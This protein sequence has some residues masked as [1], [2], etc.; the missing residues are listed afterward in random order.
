LGSRPR[1]TSAK[2]P[3]TRT[4]PSAGRSSE[5]LQQ[6]ATDHPSDLPFAVAAGHFGGHLLVGFGR[7]LFLSSLIAAALSYHNN[8]T[9]YLFALGRERVLPAV[10]G[11]TTIRS[12]APRNASLLLSGI[13]C[14]VILA[15][16]LGGAD[17]MV[18]MFYWLG[19][20]GGFGILVLIVATS[21]SVPLY[22]L[23]DGRR[24]HDD[25]ASVWQAYLAPVLAAVALGWIAW[26]IVDNF[27]ALLNVAADSPMRFAF[28][29]GYGVLVLLGLVWSLVLY[30]DRPD[31]YRAIGLGTTP[32]AAHDSA[33]T[34]PAYVAAH[35]TPGSFR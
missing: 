1:R 3:K 25:R 6:A 26:L 18:T 12:F 35:G 16:A 8:V 24:Q 32:T 19:T 20:G 33:V 13:T 14:A 7:W 22:F 5:H 27:P 15:Y 2:S 23:R 11:R 17:P 4:A 31:I 10:L 34:P 28:Q 29:V 30:L 9:R 21:V